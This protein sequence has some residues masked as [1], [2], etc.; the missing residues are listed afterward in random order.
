MGVQKILWIEASQIDY[1]RLCSAMAAKSK[2][3]MQSIC[4]NAF[5]SDT[6]E[7]EVELRRFNNDGASSSMFRGTK[8]MQDRWPG[9]RETGEIERVRTTTLDALAA[10]HG[11]GDADVLIVDVQGAELH[12]FRGAPLLLQR[13]KAV[14]TEV[15][16]EPY[17]EGGAL[18]P[19]LKSTLESHGLHEATEAPSHG[20]QLYL[21]DGAF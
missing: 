9:L 20:D 6:S 16:R 13:A 12:V 5:V 21:R 7:D 2:S 11:F 10:Q 18:Y 14:I 17:Y 4:A 8:H 3:R 19:E 1:Q 15:S